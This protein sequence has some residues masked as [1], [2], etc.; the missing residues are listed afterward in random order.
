MMATVATKYNSRSGALK[1]RYPT[2][3]TI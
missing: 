1:S 2:S 3:W